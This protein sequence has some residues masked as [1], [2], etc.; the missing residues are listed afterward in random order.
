M[1][2][3]AGPILDEASV[4]NGA[5]APAAPAPH[6]SAAPGTRPL[7]LCLVSQEYPPET[8][9]GGIGSQTY[10]KA[11][12]LAALGHRVYVVSGSTDDRAHEY[13]DGPVRVIR[14][15]GFEERL[16]IH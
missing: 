15:P 4:G 5:T 16:E 3:V 6:D 1:L 8:A 7:R 10:L 11:H 14:I 12:G 13:A 2:S 9:R